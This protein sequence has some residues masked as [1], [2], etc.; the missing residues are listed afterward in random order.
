[1]QWNIFF[2]DL[3]YNIDTETERA[4]RWLIDWLIHFYLNTVIS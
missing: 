1:M 4:K 3:V 2:L